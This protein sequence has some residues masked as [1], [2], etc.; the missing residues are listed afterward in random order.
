MGAGVGMTRPQGRKFLGGMSGKRRGWRGE[1]PGS[2]C[3]TTSERKSHA[4]N[5]R[6]ETGLSLKGTRENSGHP[7][8]WRSGRSERGWHGGLPRPKSQLN[9]G[10]L[11]QPRR[12]LGSWEDGA[13]ACRLRFIWKAEVGS[14]RH[15]G[16]QQCPQWSCDRAMASD[17][18]GRTDP[19]MTLQLPEP[20]P[21]VL[22]A[23]DSDVG[24]V[25]LSG[26][27][28]KQSP[29]R[30]GGEGTGREGQPASGPRP[31]ARSRGR[32]RSI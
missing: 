30:G 4:D 21:P 11:G 22:Q 27:R 12:G 19:K 6:L 23:G 18:W 1:R 25:G 13:Q 28:R 17:K 15:R 16:S 3:H 10:P 8:C 26:T 2:G 9:R 29:P 7:Q 31:G 24:D 5:F 20:V 14:H 32:G